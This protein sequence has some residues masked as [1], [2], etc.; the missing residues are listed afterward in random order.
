MFER[1]KIAPRTA[2]KLLPA[3]GQ[4]Q[5]GWLGTLGFWFGGD[6]DKFVSLHKGIGL[7]GKIGFLRYAFRRFR[8]CRSFPAFC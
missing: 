2:F 3:A 7:D 1:R 6:S 8:L 4:G 5:T